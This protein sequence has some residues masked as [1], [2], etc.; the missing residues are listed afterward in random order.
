MWRSVGRIEQGNRKEEIEKRE[1][2]LITVAAMAAVALK[3]V[4]VARPRREAGRAT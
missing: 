3:D 1:N 2:Q 4:S